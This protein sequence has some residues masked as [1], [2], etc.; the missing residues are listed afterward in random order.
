MNPGPYCA[1]TI[2]ARLY[3]GGTPSGVR[4]CSI[5]T[6]RGTKKSSRGFRHKDADACQS[7]QE[8]GLRINIMGEQNRSEERL[9]RRMALVLFTIIILYLDKITKMCPFH[10]GSSLPSA[11]PQ[12]RRYRRSKRFRRVARRSSPAAWRTSRYARM[13]RGGREIS[14]G[15]SIFHAKR[16]REPKVSKVARDG[17]RERG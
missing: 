1:C 8:Y 10:P 2:S 6:R 12:S 5:D 11:N 4:S 7:Q 3:C 14:G 9:C 15:A 17:C 13:R 16:A